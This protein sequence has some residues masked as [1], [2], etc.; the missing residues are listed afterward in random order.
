[1]NDVIYGMLE[2]PDVKVLL[3]D[4][5]TTYCTWVEFAVNGMAGKKYIRINDKVFVDKK[6]SNQEIID[7]MNSFSQYR[8]TV[9]LTNSEKAEYANDKP[10]NRQIAEGF[11]Y[12]GSHTN[13]LIHLEENKFW[14]DG[15][16]IEG[17][18]WKF[19]LNVRKAQG[20]TH[21]EGL[22]GNPLLTND[23]IT[24]PNLILNVEGDK[25]DQDYWMGV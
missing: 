18:A 12:L 22:E 11:K 3:I 21:L 23:D 13:V 15:S 17:K 9:V 20:A 2:H 10:T 1:V 7:V 8:K 16:S 24:L 6:E 4:K 14:K 5:W 25:F 19:R